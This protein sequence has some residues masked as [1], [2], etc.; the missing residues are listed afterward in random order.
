MSL[1]YETAEEWAEELSLSVDPD[2]ETLEAYALQRHPE[3]VAALGPQGAVLAERI[4]PGANE[5]RGTLSC[6]AGLLLFGAIGVAPI[7]GVA[8]YAEAPGVLFT[9]V[10]PVAARTAIPISSWCFGI[11]AAVLLVG[12]IV[13]LVRGAR[14]NPAL[15]G[16]AVLSFV[17]AGFATIGL[18]NVAARDEFAGLAGWLWPVR[19]AL[20]VAAVVGLAVLLR[21]RHRTP[22]GAGASDG[23]DRGQP[24]HGAQ[25]GPDAVELAAA[26]PEEDRERALADRNAALDALGRRG[27]LTG[28]TVGQARAVPLGGLGAFRWTGNP[29]A[30]T[31]ARG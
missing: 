16:Y 7:L 22:D 30:G 24:G 9:S 28:G 26:L 11:T 14:W 4:R 1:S 21:V 15:L 5:R 19:A 12:A 18:A 6:I 17:M 29:D 10:P 23:A 3:I 2:L 8:I 27:F 25:A 13:W 20:I 31:A